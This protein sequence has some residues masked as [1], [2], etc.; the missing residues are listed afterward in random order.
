MPR[1]IRSQYIILWLSNI[2]LI[3]FA[4]AHKLVRFF[5]SFLLCVDDVDDNENDGWRLK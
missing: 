1:I 4:F 5:N 2:V 3:I